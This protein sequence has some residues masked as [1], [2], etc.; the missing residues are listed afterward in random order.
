MVSQLYNPQLIAFS[1]KGEASAMINLLQ[2]TMINCTNGPHPSND[3]SDTRL[4]PGGPIPE[5][6]DGNDEPE[7][8]VRQMKASID[9]QLLD[10]TTTPPREETSGSTVHRSAPLDSPIQE[11]HD[12]SQIPMATPGRH[13]R[14]SEGALLW[15]STRS[16]YIF[17]ISVLCLC[18]LLTLP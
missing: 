5:I 14:N 16:M 2:K 1:V 12:S 15:V 7:L 13:N 18:H 11:A 6:F 3:I 4:N 8:S 10:A 17:T 9:P